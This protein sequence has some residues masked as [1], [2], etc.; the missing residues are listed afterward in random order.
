MSTRSR[1]GRKRRRIGFGSKSTNSRF[2]DTSHLTELKEAFPHL[3]PFII[4]VRSVWKVH[5]SSQCLPFTCHVPTSFLS[6]E[7]NRTDHAHHAAAIASG[8]A[9]VTM[10][11]RRRFTSSPSSPAFARHANKRHFGRRLSARPVSESRRNPFP[12]QPSPVT[13]R[14]F[15]V[16]RRRDPPRGVEPD[17]DDSVLAEPDIDVAGP[18]AAVGRAPRM[19]MTSEIGIPFSMRPNVSGLTP[20]FMRPVASQSNE[21]ALRMS[22]SSVANNT[23]RRRLTAFLSNLRRPVPQSGCRPRRRTSASL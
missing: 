16:S 4:N 5:V 18:R 22:D 2:S 3:S 15:V 20:P 9:Q 10:A 6:S 11:S 17:G 12:H 19:S 21:A 14:L 23:S 13:R 8:A 1:T 7:F